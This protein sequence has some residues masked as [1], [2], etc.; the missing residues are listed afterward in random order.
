MIVAIHFC[1]THSSHTTRNR[2]QQ[3][4]TG[5]SSRCSHGYPKE[6]DKPPEKHC[7]PFGRVQAL[8]ETFRPYEQYPTELRPDRGQSEP[9]DRKSRKGAS[10]PDNPA[11]QRC[12]GNRGKA[13]PWPKPEARTGLPSSTASEHNGR[14]PS[15]AAKE[16]HRFSL[17]DLPRFFPED[18]H[19]SCSAVARPMRLDRLCLGF[20]VDLD[21]GNK[22]FN[23]V[24]CT[25]CGTQSSTNALSLHPKGF[26]LPR[27][28]LR[29]LNAHSGVVGQEPKIVFT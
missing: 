29:G 10:A 5:I 15:N 9:C 2:Q 27:W 25:E 23:S 19:L 20:L 16:E 11:C 24:S 21:V 8:E 18:L 12:S 13:N 7:R 1:K 17:N 14:Y 22:R 26:R 6:S 28:I 4:R 3:G